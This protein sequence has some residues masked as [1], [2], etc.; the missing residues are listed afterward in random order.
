MNALGLVGWIVVSFSTGTMG[1]LFPPGDWYASLSKPD[2]NPPSWL[3]GP[4]WATLY[5]MMGISAW[6]VWR[7]G[8][9]RSQRL[10]LSFFLFQLILNAAWTP[11]F[12]GLHWQGLAFVE[13][14]LLWGGIFITIVAFRDVNRVAAWLLL[15]YLFWVGFAAILNFKLWQLN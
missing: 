9:F 11:L 10:P 2:W 4:V 3:F 15:P 5:T 8:G 12:F 13:I 6:L 1:V 7:S 14:L